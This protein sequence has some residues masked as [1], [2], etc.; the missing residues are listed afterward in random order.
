MTASGRNLIEGEVNRNERS[1]R[2]GVATIEVAGP[3]RAKRTLKT[4][5]RDKRA[6][7]RNC[8]ERYRE[9]SEDSKE[10]SIERC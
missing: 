9:D 3:G 8:T 2:W 4:I 10:F 7:K 1:P 5:Q 6:N